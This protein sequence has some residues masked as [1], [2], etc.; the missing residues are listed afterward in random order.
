MSIPN[1]VFLCYGPAV[2]EK[3]YRKGAKPAS[4]GCCAPGPAGADSCTRTAPEALARL[5]TIAKALADPI[6]L[7]MLDVM[8]QGRDCCGVI[9]PHERGVPGAGDPEGICVCEFQE[10]FGLAQSKASYHLRVLKDAGLVTEETR[11]KW[12]FYAVDTERVAT[13]LHDLREV[14]GLDAG[15]GGSARER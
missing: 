9:D 6:R 7:G 15:C 11:G 10:Q 4:S 5:A 1:Q 14:F 3:T 12:S 2:T 13:A 8:T